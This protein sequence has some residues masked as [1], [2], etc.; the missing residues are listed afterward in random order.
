MTDDRE[1]NRS[2]NNPEQQPGQQQR[3]PEDPT[4]KNPATGQD[5][6]EDQ[7]KKNE[8]EQGGQRRAS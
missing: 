4:R 5:I 3:N 1:K 2:Q 6:D 8:R 7:E